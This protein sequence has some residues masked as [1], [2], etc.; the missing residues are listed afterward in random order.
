[1][2]LCII[3]VGLRIKASLVARSSHLSGCFRLLAPIFWGLSGCFRLL[4]PN[5]FGRWQ[6]P[7]NGTML[8][9]EYRLSGRDT[10]KWWRHSNATLC[11]II[12]LNILHS[13]A[14]GMQKLWVRELMPSL[15]PEPKY[16]TQTSSISVECKPPAYREYGLH[17]I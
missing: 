6:G 16:N 12:Y 4:A 2:Q 3:Y 15:T 13:Q 11:N 17:I 1:M 5:F 14:V 8:Q 10:M 7:M 9:Y